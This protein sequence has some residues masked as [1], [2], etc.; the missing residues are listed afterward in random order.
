MFF[1]LK[2][3]KELLSISL[4]KIINFAVCILIDVIE[5]ESG[6][7][8]NR[9]LR[10]PAVSLVISHNLVFAFVLMYLGNTRSLRVEFDALNH[11]FL[12]KLPCA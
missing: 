9:N 1:F 3:T 7:E 2:K 12:F 8:T 10:L 6:H 5:Y 11:I 4:C